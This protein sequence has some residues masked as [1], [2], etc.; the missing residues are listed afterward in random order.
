M[1]VKEKG[2]NMEQ[3]NVRDQRKERKGKVVQ[4]NYNLKNE[5]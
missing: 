1:D 3:V 5:K 4:L 2:K